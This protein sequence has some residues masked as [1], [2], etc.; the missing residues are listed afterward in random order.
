[1]KKVARKPECNLSR[2][3]VRDWA[4][5]IFRLAR[6]AGRTS[7][8]QQ[9]SEV[10]NLLC[11]SL[12]Q[13]V[14]RPSAAFELEDFF[15]HLEEKSRAHKDELLDRSGLSQYAIPRPTISQMMARPQPQAINPPAP[16]PMLPAPTAYSYENEA[17]VATD[18]EELEAKEA[19]L[20]DE[21]YY[22]LEDLTND[23]DVEYNVVNDNQTSSAGS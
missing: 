2:E 6:A 12:K 16:R 8:E 22:M 4:G 9:M 11:P 17:Y 14:A 19:R 10:Y 20:A 1:M 5:G 13:L 21:G 23:E 18:D 15:T 3:S 7:T